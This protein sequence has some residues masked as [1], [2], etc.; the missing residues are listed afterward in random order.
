MK[1]LNLYAGIGG[2]R[3]LWGDEHEITSVEN[4]PHI[5]DVY[6]S[7]FIADTVICADAHQYLLDHYKEFDFIW[8]S[9]PCPSHSR[10]GL[11]S[12]KMY[13]KPRYFDATLWQEIVFLK[14]FA[15][16]KLK[17][18]VEN[19]KPYYTPLIDPTVEL[20]RHCFWSNFEIAPKTIDS[21]YRGWHNHGVTNLTRQ[22]LEKAYGIELPDFAIGKRK[23]L[24]N[25][26]KPEIG[27]YILE[28][29][30]E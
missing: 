25:A 6:A 26:V 8:T 15:P 1:I 2:N 19:V 13:N 5:C 21:G 30:Y 12:A 18:V 27:K 10:L 17:W 3:W 7:R 16:K 20:H 22:Q 28:C 14:H 29:A 23:L 24:Q 4:D 9:P 11:Q